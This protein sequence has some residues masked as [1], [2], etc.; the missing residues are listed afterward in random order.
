MSKENKGKVIAF[1]E[2]IA[3]RDLRQLIGFVKNLEFGTAFKELGNCS[4]G[5]DME[6]VTRGE[7]H[8][9]HAAMRF[10]VLFNNTA[11]IIYQTEDNRCDVSC[12]NVAVAVGDYEIDLEKVPV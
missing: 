1:A 3:R 5:L 8:F 7:N 6:L 9:I 2:E 11:T 12:E 4:S 10:D